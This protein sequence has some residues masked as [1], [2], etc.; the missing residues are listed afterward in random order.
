M[1]PPLR[2]KAMQE[3][4]LEYVLAGKLDIIG[5]DH[6][7]HPISRKDDPEKP[8]SGIPGILFWPRGIELLRKFG[9]SSEL[10]DNMIFHNANK[11]FK[12][13]LTPQIVDIKYD[14]TLWDRYGYNPF[15]RLDT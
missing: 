9:I 4:L 11:L 12:W 14:P 3:K 8:A 1:N 13:N 5:T 15:I 6:A 10:L 2:S 7:P